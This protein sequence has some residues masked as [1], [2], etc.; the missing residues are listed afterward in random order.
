PQALR[1]INAGVTKMDSLLTGLLHYSRLG[2]IAL[3]IHPL[4]M[5]V[6]L[7]EILA[8]MKFQ[9]D[10]AR[11]EV[12]VEPLPGCFGDTAQTSQVFT[13]LI[14]NALKYRSAT[15]PLRVVI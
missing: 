6:L 12:Q 7:A 11:A 10:E 15:R 9:L 5:N 14:D 1:F 8:A 2:R 13:N 4:D 3:T